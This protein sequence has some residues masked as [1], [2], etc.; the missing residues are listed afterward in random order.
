MKSFT[1]PILAGLLL[2]VT[3]LHSAMAAD[4]TYPQNSYASGD[5]LT[6]KSL[7]S[8]FN[9][10]KAQVNDNNARVTVNASD[11]AAMQQAITNLQA[12]VATLTSQI[13]A[14]NASNTMALDPYI[15]VD[16]LSDTR[17]PIVRLSG[18]NLQVVNGL[19]STAPAVGAQPNGLGNIIIGYDEATNSTQTLCSWGVYQLQTDCEANGF[20]WGNLHKYGQHNL[21]VGPEHNYSRFG[22][23]VAG[24]RNSITGDYASVTGGQQNKAMGESSGITA[25]FNNEATGIRSS[26][27]GGSVNHAYGDQ[28]SILAGSGNT[29]N[30]YFAAVVGGNANHATGNGSSISGGYGNTASGTRASIL[31]GNSNTVSATDGTS[32]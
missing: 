9:E 8:R 32:P 1:K 27:H 3:G 20:Y 22:G 11:I 24:F 25:G 17:G 31:G 29:T 13:N 18:V 19:G 28:S 15:T 6:A 14:I 10:I 4:I 26:I 12:T 23:I 16:T 2:M 7:N 5:T 30:N 21:V